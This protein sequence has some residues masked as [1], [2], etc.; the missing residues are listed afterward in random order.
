[1]LDRRL[2]HVPG[3]AELLHDLDSVVEG[4][5]DVATDDEHD[6][7]GAT[8]AYERARTTALVDQARAHLAEVDAALGRLAEGSYGRCVVCGTAISPE[9]L[10][11]R[12]AATTC[13]RC[14][15]RR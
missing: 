6:P 3:R 12:P 5:R 4:S 15:S 8:I 7:E 9:R 10:E 11:A 13:I 14:A 2:D 1:M